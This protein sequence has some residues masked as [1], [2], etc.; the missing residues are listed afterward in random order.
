M[1]KRE[2]LIVISC[3]SILLFAAII[4]TAG[5]LETGK[6]GLLIIA[7]GS[8][9]SQWNETVFNI[10]QEVTEIMGKRGIDFYDEIRVALM[11]VSEPSINTV[12][13]DFEKKGIERIYAIPLFI[14]PSGHS[15]YDVPT[16]LGVYSDK[17][18][19]ETIKSEGINIVNTDIKITIGPTLS[20]GKVLQEIMLDRVHDLST[21]TSVEAVVLLSHGAAEYEPIWRNLCLEIGSYITA[22]TGIH[23]FDYAFVEVGQS[24]LSH[25]VPIILKTAEKCKRTI[26]VGLYLALDI[27]AMAKS[28]SFNSHMMKLDGNTLFKDKNIVFSDKGLL[29]D[30]RISE[31]IVDRAVEWIEISY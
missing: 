8:N 15:A 14:T 19:V 12:I 24:F 9:H 4:S 20:Y 2:M 31:W 25:G 1:G 17:K 18:I 26:V 6:N 7:H 23:C 16:I 3:V 10:E 11:E 28:I 5:E 13:K 27:E 30:K 21:N 29:P 22:K